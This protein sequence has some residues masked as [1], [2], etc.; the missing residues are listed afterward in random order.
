[1]LEVVD[2]SMLAKTSGRKSERQTVSRQVGRFF[3]L[4]INSGPDVDVAPAPPSCPCV[5]ERSLCK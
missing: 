1:M 2:C 5:R 4:I 3:D